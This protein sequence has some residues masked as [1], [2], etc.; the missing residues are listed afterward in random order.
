MRA[1]HDTILTI[2]LGGELARVIV[3]KSAI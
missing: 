3:H 2:D 1:H